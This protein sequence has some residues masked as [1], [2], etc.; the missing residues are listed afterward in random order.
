MNAHLKSVKDFHQALSIPRGV[1]EGGRLSDKD[2]I[3]Y[4]AMLM[5]T[6]SELL[7]AMRAGEMPEMLLGLVELA[8]VALA[9]IAKQDGDVGDKPAPWH[10]DWT[11][12]SVVKVVSDKI[13]A[14]SV[15]QAGAYSDMYF[16]CIDLATNFVNADFDK[17]FET[18][19]GNNMERIAIS[20]KCIYDDSENLR[21]RKL[22]KAPDLSDC[23][24]E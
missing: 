4:Q 19:H 5:E 12:L 11:L 3:N 20:G 24:Y 2:V 9:A 14:C 1:V 6:G 17:A 10:L 8:Y 23:L 16:L 18:I 7:K 21:Q 22:H 15:G 13:N